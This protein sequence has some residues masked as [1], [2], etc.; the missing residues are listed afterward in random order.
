MTRTLLALSLLAA[1]LAAPAAVG[2]GPAVPPP[3]AGDGAPPAPAGADAVEDGA[4]PDPEAGGELLEME[5]AEAALLPGAGEVLRE[6][7][8]LSP[9]SPWRERLAAPLSLDGGEFP[10]A[11]E[12]AGLGGTVLPFPLDAVRARYDIPLDDNE[13]VSAY[14]A[15]FQGPGRKVFTRWLARSSRWIPL[16]RDILRQHQMPEDLVYLSMIESGFSMRA[17]SR[18]HASGPWQFIS[19]TGRRYGLRDD[20]WVDERRDFIKATH[21]AARYLKNLHAMWGDWYLAW[22]SYNAGPGRVKRAIGQHATQ[23]FWALHE[24]KGAFRNETRGYVPKLIAAALIAKFPERFGFTDVPFE[25]PLIWDEVE[26]PAATDIDV[27]ARCAGTTAEAIQEL[28]PELRRWATPPTNGRPYRLRVPAGTRERFSAAYAQIKPSERFTFRAYVVQPGDTLG[29]IALMFGTSTE[30]VARANHIKDPRRLRPGQQLV[31][32]TP[33][34]VRGRGLQAAAVRPA[35]APP[36]PGRSDGDHHVL[37]EGETLGHVAMQYGVTVA[38]LRRWNAIRN[39]RKLQI[40]QR[41]RV[42]P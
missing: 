42:R 6:I 15:F 11:L 27:I 19:G 7:R 17:Y 41:L 23:D 38:Q 9:A 34:G 28:N 22:A 39:V 16:F 5:A 26:V 36:V 14:L 2:P 31:V 13:Q 30:A 33:P 8:R 10:A 12:D 21:A 29:H 18:A 32:P 1:P 4:P 40:G 37:G 35:P 25:Q 24:A 3:A 20:F